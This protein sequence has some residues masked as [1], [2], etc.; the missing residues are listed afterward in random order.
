MGEPITVFGEKEVV[1]E[2]TVSQRELFFTEGEDALVVAR[3]AFA[4]WSL[5]K[6]AQRIA[7]ARQLRDSLPALQAFDAALRASESAACCL[8]QVSSEI[9]DDRPIQ[10]VQ[11]SPDGALMVSCGWGGSVALWTADASCKRVGAFRAAAERL[12]GIAWH[13]FA[14]PT[15]HLQDG[16]DTAAAAA[17]AGG[18]GGGGGGEGVG[19]GGS[20]TVALATGCADGTAALWTE[21]GKLLRKL[22]GHTDRLGRVAFHPMGHHLATASYDMT[23][24]LWD[25]ESGSCLVEQEGHSREVYAVAFHPDGSLAGSVGLDAYGR[26]WDLRTGRTAFVLQGHVKQVLTL[27]FHP[28]G[29]TV[30]TGG[31]DHTVKVWDLRKK[32]AIYTIPAHSSL[33]STVRWQP[34]TGHTLLTAGYDCQAKLWSYRNFKCLRVLSGHEGKVM[35]ADLCPVWQG[36]GGAG[37]GLGGQFE[38]LVGSVSYDRTIKLWAPEDMPEVFGVAG[39]DSGS[40]G[41]NGDD[42]DVDMEDGMDAGIA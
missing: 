33:V 5:P 26:I 36:S 11:F 18:G 29:F 42:G 17:A 1:I 4:A 7:A 19:Q 30:A 37:V 22:E 14:R 35:G 32:K 15:L 12:T 9:G 40:E 31:D 34:H 23:W 8:S 21:H 39:E 3:K 2:E 25:L 13:P 20:V 28:D 16:A 24:R 38:A 41:D 27:D 6:A 10:G